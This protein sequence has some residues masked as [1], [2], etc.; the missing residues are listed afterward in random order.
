MEGVI[1]FAVQ[2]T[3]GTMTGLDGPKNLLETFI[4]HFVLGGLSNITAYESFN[5]VMPWIVF[6]NN[7]RNTKKDFV[8][9]L[10]K[11]I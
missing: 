5:V 10:L 11:R 8:C 9:M 4:V 3:E 7:G 6:P 1:K 2:T